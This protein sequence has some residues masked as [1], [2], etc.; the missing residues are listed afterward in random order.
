VTATLRVWLHGQHLADLH[1]LNNRTLRLRYTEEALG[2]WGIGSRPLSLSLPLTP[3]RVQGDALERFC[4]NL[5]PE[6]AV[7][8]VLERENGVRPG[9]AFGLLTHVGREC[10]G[11]IQF[12]AEDTPLG[13]GGLVP[14]SAG[15]VDTLVRD[16]PTHHVPD[17]LAVSASLGGVQDKVLLTR[18]PDGW[19]WPSDGAIS[20]HLVKPQPVSP[21]VPI[22][23]IV[24]YEHWALHLARA[25]GLRAAHAELA[26]FDGRQALV[27]ERFDRVD[28][29]RLHQ[30]DVTQSLGLA[31]RDKYE[32]AVGERR[33]STF[34]ALAAP[35]A[36][37]P[38]G[39][40]VD[41]L[42]QVTFNTAI[43]NGD[44]HS[45]NYSIHIGEGA[46]VS[47]SPLY[48]VAPVF[49][50]A[51][52]YRHAGHAVDEQVYLPYLTAAHLVSEAVHWGLGRQVAEEVVASTLQ[53]TL[54]AVEDLGEPDD[55][56]VAVGA[57]VHAR[58][59]GLLA[60]AG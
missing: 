22:P 53:S 24:R 59:S 41:L 36:V 9:D 5:L 23:E 54:A 51:A 57:A 39:L 38:A 3:K 58:V 17:G 8:A 43:G 15:D 10:A 46:T 13:E 6:G 21:Q 50:V 12:T 18:T 29:R 31:A 25:A 34:A 4:D 7:R 14:L 44:A 27:V 37:D 35:E 19:A 28:G 1:Q 47:T 11:A 2:R 33:L 45:K 30:E 16:L 42:R 52:T 32:S 60:R 56:P 20:T 26:W 55:V 40:L 49:L 48:D